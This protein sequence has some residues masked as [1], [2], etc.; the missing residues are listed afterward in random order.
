MFFRYVCHM[1]M[2]FIK[3]NSNHGACYWNYR[4]YVLD[5]VFFNKYIHVSDK[6]Q[7]IIRSIKSLTVNSRFYRALRNHFKG[8][9][10]TQFTQIT[11]LLDRQECH[12]WYISRYSNLVSSQWVFVSKLISKLHNYQT[13]WNTSRCKV[14]HMI[15][16][17]MWQKVHKLIFSLEKY[18][19]TYHV[20]NS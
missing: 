19:F 18:I 4:Q 1:N 9:F 8:L 17:W 3:Y 13:F 16:C 15:I 12:K 14:P 2:I 20:F 11:L 10:V 7:Y 5:N 6:I